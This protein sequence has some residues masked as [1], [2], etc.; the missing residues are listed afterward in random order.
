VLGECEEEK[1][2]KKHEWMHTLFFFL[3]SL[4]TVRGKEGARGCEMMG[5]CWGVMGDERECWGGGGEA[6]R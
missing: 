6:K 1:G 5:E 3:P 2:T 4:L